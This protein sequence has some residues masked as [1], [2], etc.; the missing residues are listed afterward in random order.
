MSAAARQHCRELSTPEIVCLFIPKIKKKVATEFGIDLKLLS[1][2]SVEQERGSNTGATESR[3]V[4]MPGCS[5]PLEM[6]R[7]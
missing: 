1:A 2:I 3:P 6:S 5:F 4:S 7:Y